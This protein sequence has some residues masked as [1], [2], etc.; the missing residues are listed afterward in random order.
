V[1]EE[2]LR[3][4]LEVF[5]LRAEVVSRELDSDTV[6]VAVVGGDLGL[7]IGPR[8]QTLT[9]IQDLTRGVLQRSSPTDRRRVL[10]DVGGYRQARREALERFS[11][12]AAAEV[13]STG[14][15]KVLEPMPPADRK[16]VHDTVNTIDGVGTVS[17]GEDPQRRVVIVR[18]DD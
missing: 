10:V 7:L 5:D 17:E 9:A 11:R 18:K 12:A 14:V 16:V 6:E 3:G 13:L 2:F 4:L 8:G 15:S 1:A